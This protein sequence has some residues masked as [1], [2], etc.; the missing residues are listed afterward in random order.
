MELKLCVQ[1]PKK[2]EEEEEEEEEKAVSEDIK[3]WEVQRLFCI[4]HVNP[5]TQHSEGLIA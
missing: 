3:P 5:N 1:K 4:A 2:E